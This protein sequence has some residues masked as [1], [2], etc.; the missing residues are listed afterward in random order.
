MKNNLNKY[1]HLLSGL[2]LAGFLSTTLNAHSACQIPPPLSPE[3]KLKPLKTAIQL[4]QPSQL[5]VKEMD[6]A[7][8]AW[9]YFVNNYNEKTG[10]VNAVNNYP[11]TTMWD[12]A[13]YLGGMISAYE[14]G[15]IKKN[16]FD[17]RLV[18]L[19]GTLNSMDFFRNELPNKVYHTET[20]IKV[21]YGNNPGEI[22]FSA[23]DLGRLLIMLKVIKERYQYH[24]TAIDKF[25]LRWDF[26]HVLNKWGLM[27]GAVLDKDKK[28]LYVQ[29]GRLG[30]EE[31]A[32]KGFQ[33]W[34]FNTQRASLVEPYQY[35]K[36]YEIDIP[37]DTRDPRKLVAHNYVVTESYV[38]DAIEMNWDLVSDKN[39]ADD[40]H[41]DVW[42]ED[43]A[44]RIY[45]VQEARYRHTGII[46]A[47]TEHQLD[48]DPY[49]VYDTI[50]TDG[51][52]WNTITEDSKHVPQYSAIALKGALG[53]WGIWDTAY[54]QTIFDATSGLY[55]KEKGFYEGLFENGS[56]VIKTFTANNNGIIL[57]T[58]LYKSQGKLL[59]YAKPRMTLWDKTLRDDFD[60]VT[61]QGLISCVR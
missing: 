12:T 30:Y 9:Q 39:S 29:E 52:A 51:F 18:T 28:T 32:A 4:R 8:V 33:L 54:T 26:R 23:L 48:R 11:S 20:A 58:L 36:I 43:F 7:R 50:Y 5:T 42:M 49:F 56:G 44:K 17:M 34:G 6:M 37:Y 47:R 10:L 27:Y 14:L 55:D 21:D 53:L 3:E 2:L 35:T 45:A 15:I 41:T 61:R 31:Y 13:S 19:L 16:T 40:E 59:K 25:V 22:G 24:A 1:R 46:T 38:L 60:K 57:E